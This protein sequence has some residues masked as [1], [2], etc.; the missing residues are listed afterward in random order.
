MDEKFLG[1]HESYE[2]LKHVKDNENN[3]R[4]D[5]EA[6]AK[7]STWAAGKIKL[8]EDQTT[9]YKK[10]IAGIIVQK[11]INEAL[12]KIVDDLAGQGVKVNHK[13]VEKKFLS[14]KEALQ[15]EDINK[16]R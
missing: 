16:G 13:E 2:E 8:D 12:S 5:I 1:K 9:V 10:D 6:S 4:Q 14:A 7:L 15:K 3:F 11:G